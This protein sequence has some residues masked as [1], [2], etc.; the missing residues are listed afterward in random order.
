M[1]AYNNYKESQI[2]W[3]GQVPA[4]WSIKKLSTIFKFATGFTPSTG[5]SE[6]YQGGDIDWVTIADMKG[7]YIYD[8]VSKITAKAIEGRKPIPK[9]SLLY[10]FKLSVG[11]VAFAGKDIFTNEAIFAIF[12][13]N[14][15][16]LDYFYYLLPTILIY[17]TN[18]NIYGAKLLNQEIIKASKLVYPPYDEQIQIAQYLDYKTGQIDKL[19]NDK[20]KLIELLEE[21]ILVIVS[22]ALTKGLGE[23]TPMKDSDIEWL[24]SIPAHWKCK[25]MKYLCDIGTGGKDTE[26]RE[27]EGKYPFYVRSQT[28]ERISTFSFDGEAVLTAGDGVGVCKVWHYVNG[29]FDY[30][31]RVYRMSHFN[32]ISGKY[33]YYYLKTNFEKEVKKLSAKSTVDSLRRPMFQNFIVIY[34]ST[35]EQEEIV[36]HIETEE[37][38]ID[39]ITQRINQEIQLLQEYRTALIWEVVTGK[40]DVGNEVPAELIPLAS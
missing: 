30:H 7:K 33:L 17:N 38:R 19:I 25:R 13:N 1:E 9:G 12:P 10:S 2:D 29:K 26:N 6:Y 21:E 20:Q 35:A 28:I 8:S 24:E 40:I 5:N 36:N 3:I 31:Q 18:E 14:D 34:G 27:D 39:K 32:E 23:N 4:H 22:N 15:L 11:K 37:R 16:C